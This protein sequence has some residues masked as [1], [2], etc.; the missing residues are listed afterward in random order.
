MVLHPDPDDF[1][2]SVVR[3]SCG[4]AVGTARKP[5]GPAPWLPISIYVR[6][7]RPTDPTWA[8]SLARG[9]QRG[10]MDNFNDLVSGIARSPKTW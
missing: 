2:A 8:A 6:N 9:W 7:N 1:R 4:G 10:C 5:L 3:T